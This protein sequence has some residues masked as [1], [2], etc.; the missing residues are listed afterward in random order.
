MKEVRITLTEQDAILFR[1]FRQFQTDFQILLANGFF[2]FKG[3]QC[4]C[5][6]DK[7]G[8]IRKIEINKIT[9]TS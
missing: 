3:G 8:Q 9:F 6:K 2:T 4:I 7:D 1:Q 5:H